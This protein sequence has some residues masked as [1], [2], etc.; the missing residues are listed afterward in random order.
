[1]SQAMFYERIG[2][3]GWIGEVAKKCG[4]VVMT[5]IEMVVSVFSAPCSTLTLH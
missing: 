1:M 4:D 5:M 2:R 3:I